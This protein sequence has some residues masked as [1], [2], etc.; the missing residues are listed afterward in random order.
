MFTGVLLTYLSAKVLWLNGDQNERIVRRQFMQLGVEH[1]VD[2]IPEWDM[3][4]YRRFRKLQNKFKYDLVVIDSLDGCNDSNPYEENRREY[5]LPIKRLARRNGQDFPACA[6]VI[7]HHNTKSGQFRGTSAI[8]AAVDETWNMRKLTQQEIAERG[9]YPNSRCV[10]VEKSRDDREGKQMV[11]RLMKDF[12][13]QI[14]HLPEARGAAVTASQQVLAVLDL[15]RAER[16]PWT[17]AELVQHEEVGGE[18]TER[19]NRSVLEKLEQQKLIE[20]CAP[21][22]ADAVKGRGR[23]P[24]YYQAV[25]TS[26]PGF[27]SRARGESRKSPEQIEKPALERDLNCSGGPEKIPSGE[28]KVG[29]TDPTAGAPGICSAPDLLQEAGKNQTPSAAGD[30]DLFPPARVNRVSSAEALGGIAQV[31]PAVADFWT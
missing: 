29:S 31:R 26:I 2:V 17:L 5:A 6:I 8:R 24:V 27:T 13:Y 4:W 11:F 9:L 22:P 1:G 3:S 30:L 19:M 20:R 28:I 7:I 16:R 21:P 15:M 23:R 10:T 18:H 12:T 25:G 14:R